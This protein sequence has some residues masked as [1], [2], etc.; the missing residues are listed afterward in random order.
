MNPKDKRSPVRRVLTRIV[1]LLNHLPGADQIAVRRYTVADEKIPEA[2]DGFTMAMISDLHGR[3]FGKAQ[4]R[5]LA[6]IRTIQPDIIVCAGD[7]VDLDYTG[8]D[9]RCCDVLIRGLRSIAP[10]Y[11]ILGNHEARAKHKTQLIQGMRAQGVHLLLNQGEILTREGQSIEIMGF[12]TPYAAPLKADAKEQG[13]LKRQYQRALGHRSPAFRIVL[14]HRPELLALYEELGL[15]LVLSGHAHGGLMKLPGN[16][17]L[18]APGQGWLPR[19]T[20]GLYQKGK[21]RMIVSCG[22][23]G[24]R[25]GIAPEI[26]NIT[27]KAKNGLAQS[28]RNGGYYEALGRTISS[29]GK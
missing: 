16:R 18:L 25:I 22:L 7:W 24:P 9:R 2:F 29:A 14:A 12:Q 15:D 23:G 3:W 17:R 10:V 28:A 20:H 13:K 4:E 21:T 19:Y 27:L 6:A 8:A 11:G 26:Q 1:E 5:L